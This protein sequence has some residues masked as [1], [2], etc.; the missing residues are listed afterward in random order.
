MGNNFKIYN[1]KGLYNRNFP[2]KYFHNTKS[3][4]KEVPISYLLQK[5]Y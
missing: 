4:I 1:L 2:L 5:V 3:R